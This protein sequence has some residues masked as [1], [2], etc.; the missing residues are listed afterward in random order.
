MTHF[1]PH[2]ST[3]KIK[4]TGAPGDLKCLLIENGVQV[5]GDTDL[6]ELFKESEKI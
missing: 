1:S 3:N 2:L 4:L 5:F 6:Y